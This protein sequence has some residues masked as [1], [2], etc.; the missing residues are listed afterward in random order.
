MSKSARALRKRRQRQESSH[1]KDAYREWNIRKVRAFH[2]ALDLWNDVRKLRVDKNRLCQPFPRITIR[3]SQDMPSTATTEHI[4]KQIRSA[5]ATAR[6]SL[7]NG[8]EESALDF[9]YL[10]WPA[11]HRLHCGTWHDPPAGLGQ[12]RRKVGR[13][14]ETMESAGTLQ[15]AEQGLLSPVAW[16]LATYS[17]INTILYH[18]DLHR[19]QKRDGRLRTC[20]S[21]HQEPARVK[22]VTIDGK[23]RPAYRCA[24]PSSLWPIEWVVWT[25]K[26]LGLSGDNQQ[27]PVYVQQHAL[28]SLYGRKSRLKALDVLPEYESL[29][30]HCLW[31]S[32]ESPVFR[33][34][35][36]DPSTRFVEFWIDEYKLGYLVVRLLPDKAVVLT[37][38]FLTMDGTPEGEELWR[39]LRLNRMDKAYL[40][41]DDL[42]TYVATDIRT[43][44]R[45]VSVLGRCGCGHLCQV[46]PSNIATP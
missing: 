8:R 20:L 1:R 15:S 44:E 9:V 38:L 17:R 11:L 27:W 25:G 26:M 12:F 41:L 45:L 40:G 16:V 21:L 10:L 23:R 32:L 42:S 31:E 3:A 5:M 24:Q 35:G 30:H 13:A 6:V 36:T 28:N 2:D 14:V 37:F 22:T 19:E 29:V 7:P 34:W 4:L 39:Q 46:T 33:E 18:L 43:D